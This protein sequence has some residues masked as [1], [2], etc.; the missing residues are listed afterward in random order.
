MEH[1]N[2]INSFKDDAQDYVDFIKSLIEKMHDEDINQC[3]FN[4]NQPEK[5]QLKKLNKEENYQHDKKI[6][7]KDVLAFATIFFNIFTPNNEI[8]F[9]PEKNYNMYTFYEINKDKIKLAWQS[10]PDKSGKEYTMIF[11]ILN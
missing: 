2:V 4:S 8:V 1:V 9:N 3:I 7:K 11:Q 5:I 10:I 6:D